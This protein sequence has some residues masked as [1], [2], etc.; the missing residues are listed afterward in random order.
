M[1][2]FDKATLRNTFLLQKAKALTNKGFIPEEQ[3]VFIFSKLSVLKGQENYLIRFAFFLLG[4]L[5]FLSI[6][7]LISLM[8]L[9]VFHVTFSQNYVLCFLPMIIGF[10]G[11][12]CFAKPNHFR[13]GLNEGFI[14][15]AQFSFFALL[16][17]ASDSPLL[18]CTAMVVVGFIC[19]LR[20]VNS[21][22]A[23]IS[24]IGIT[25]LVINL[26]LE[27]TANYLPFRLLTYLFLLPFGLLLLSTLLYFTQNQ[28]SKNV[29]GFYYKDCLYYIRAFSL[30]L[31]YFSVIYFVINEFFS[32]FFSRENNS[33]AFVFYGLTFVVP[34][35]YIIYSLFIKDK[36]MLHI[37]FLTL[38][39]SFFTI[40]LYYQLMPIENALIFSGIILFGLS[41]F[42]MRKLKS[43]TSGITFEKDRGSNTNS[44]LNAQAI[45][46]TQ[47]DLKIE[48]ATNQDML[49]GG[50]G[51][52]G[53]GSG[54]E[55]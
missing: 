37:G 36:I 21:L 52:S 19:C 50:G 53:G 46:I 44:L 54:G 9:F 7:V 47:S 51:F 14:C 24:V 5:L 26:L 31:G 41:F 12:E 49:F 39:F 40:R 32:D 3:F 15:G 22:S 27:H 38:S 18:V 23:L 45:I 55:F 16:E 35:F 48:S 25:G 30:I 43:K 33:F 28:I 11:I 42:F 8:A 1:I 20:Y 34:V 17:L 6:L 13:Q 10:M 29:M 4:N 2:R